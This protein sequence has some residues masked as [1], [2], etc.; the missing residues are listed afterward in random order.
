[1]P[2]DKQILRE[3]LILMNALTQQPLK[4]VL[5]QIKLLINKGKKEDHLH[6]IDKLER[7]TLDSMHAIQN[8]TNSGINIVSTKEGVQTIADGKE[9]PIAKMMIG[10]LGTLADFELQHKGKTKEGIAKATVKGVYSGGS[11]GSSE[12]IIQFTNKASTQ[13]ILKYLSLGEIINRTALLSKTSTGKVKKVKRFVKEG[14][15]SLQLFSY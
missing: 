13:G 2:I 10:I 6:I 7:T 4:T 1:M 8:F 12:D 9:N 5:R 14:N 11:I 15:I 3:L